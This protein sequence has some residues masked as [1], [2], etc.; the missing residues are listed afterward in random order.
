MY[1]KISLPVN[2]QTKKPVLK[3]IVASILLK[4][5]NLLKTFCFYK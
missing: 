3:S 5:Y 1:P 4:Y 2:I